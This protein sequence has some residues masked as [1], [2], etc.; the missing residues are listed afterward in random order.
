[1]NAEKFDE[2]MNNILATATTILD[3][4]TK[5][6]KAFLALGICFLQLFVIFI[7]VVETFVYF[8]CANNPKRE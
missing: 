1:M 2:T 8:Y 4:Y 3:K 5:T 7:K 6:P